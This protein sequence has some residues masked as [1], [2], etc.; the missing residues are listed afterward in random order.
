MRNLIIIIAVLILLY[1]LVNWFSRTPSKQVAS[2][3]RKYALYGII[4]LVIFFVV[5]GR[6][7]WLYGLIAGF[8]PVGQRLFTAWNTVNHF[9]RFGLGSQK[10]N[11]STSTSGQTSTIETQYLNMSLNHDTGE[12]TGTVLQGKYKGHRLNEL[13]LKQLIELLKECRISDD[14]DSAAVLESYLDRYH[15]NGDANNWHDQYQ[16]A[17]NDYNR[18]TANNNMEAEEA[19]QI[20]GLQQGASKQEI[21]D[22][23][24]RLMQKFHP[25][26]GGSTYLSAKINRAKDY[27]LNNH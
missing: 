15:S 23:H 17:N 18:T 6:M 8:I 26:R 27:L 7:H 11:T 13:S 2:A 5:T 4:A 22:A 12:M 21:K 16:Q 10:A 3:L 14:T 25:D 20:L 1:L 9:R 19:Y 24:R